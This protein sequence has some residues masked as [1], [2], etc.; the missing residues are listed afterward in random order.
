MFNQI[1]FAKLLLKNGSHVENPRSGH[2]PIHRSKNL[3]ATKLLIDHGANVNLKDFRNNSPIHYAL[4]RNAIDMVKLLI[5]N[6][7]IVED[8][9]KDKT[10]LAWAIDQSHIEIAKVLI[11]NG[12]NVNTKD[13]EG[14]SP[15]HYGA[16]RNSIDVVKLLIENGASIHDKND[17]GVTPFDLAINKGR[18]IEFIEF[19]IAK[20][21]QVNAIRNGS[22]GTPINQF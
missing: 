16:K 2:Q 1:E 7:A 3:E 15:I 22:I 12:V 20:G 5:E 8:N 17:E 13:L 21:A 14:N 4:N 11:A 6:G 9:F 18:D 10:L 19:L